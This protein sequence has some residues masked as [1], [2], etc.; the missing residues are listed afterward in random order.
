M[1]YIYAPVYAIFI[2][3]YISYVIHTRNVYV[4]VYTI[5]TRVYTT[6]H[7]YTAIT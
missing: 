1:I 7:W 3:L 2:K 4:R 5:I 6:F